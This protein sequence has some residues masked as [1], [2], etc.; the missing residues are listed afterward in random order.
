[1]QAVAGLSTT[2]TDMNIKSTGR[3]TIAESRLSW[4]RP[5]SVDGIQVTDGCNLVTESFQSTLVDDRLES[6][7]KGDQT[8]D[9]GYPPY[10]LQTSHVTSPTSHRVR[11]G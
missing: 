8:L 9:L 3:I 11:Q 5:A 7:A 6:V 2:T 1:M 4:A 10:I